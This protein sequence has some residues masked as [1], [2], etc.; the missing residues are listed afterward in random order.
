[1][2]DAIMFNN[3]PVPL[4]YFRMEMEQEHMDEPFNDLEETHGRIKGSPPVSQIGIKQKLNGSPESKKKGP[5]NPIIGDSDDLTGAN[6]P[7]S[8]PQNSNNYLVLF[9]FL[10]VFS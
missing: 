4:D 10:F 7:N 5:R 3:G 2:V 8:A 6:P 1:M 9:T